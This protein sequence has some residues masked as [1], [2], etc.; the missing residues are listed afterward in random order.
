[1][2]AHVQ[3]VDWSFQV[4]HK[5]SASMLDVAF[6]QSLGEGVAY[7]L[8]LLLFALEPGNAVSL[9]LSR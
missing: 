9:Y 5:G 4:A 8:M 1:M 7:L 3:A 2:V 6:G